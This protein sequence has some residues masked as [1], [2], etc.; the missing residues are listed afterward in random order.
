MINNAKEYIN[1]EVEF[2]YKEVS[3]FDGTKQ[4]YNKVKVIEA[5]YDFEKIEEIKEDV[6]ISTKTVKE[7]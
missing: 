4:S 7:N 1:K 2:I 6:Q 5:F 3:M